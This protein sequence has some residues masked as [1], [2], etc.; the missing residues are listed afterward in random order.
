MAVGKLK[1]VSIGGANALDLVWDDGHEARIGLWSIIAGHK[2]LTGIKPAKAFA[3]VK[4]SKDKWSVEWPGGIDFGATQLRRWAD[5][6]AGDVMP[7]ADFRAWMEEH[8][9]TL[10]SAA[11]GLGLSRRMVAYYASG[12]KPIPRTVMLA[13]KGWSAQYA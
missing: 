13:T 3:Q 1:S 7:V 6:Q 9:L 10:E 4:L 12:E 11:K 5:E 8:R 2:G